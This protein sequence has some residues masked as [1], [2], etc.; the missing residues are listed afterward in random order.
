MIN[1]YVADSDWAVGMETQRSD[2]CIERSTLVLPAVWTDVGQERSCT[3]VSANPLPSA[4]TRQGEQ[5][6][7]GIC[8]GS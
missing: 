3:Q 2:V 1:L 5:L 6:I 8:A 7:C 4:Y